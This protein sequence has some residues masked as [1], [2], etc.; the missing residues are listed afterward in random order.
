MRGYTKSKSWGITG[1]D[2]GT[3]FGLARDAWAHH[4]ALTGEAN[5]FE[6]A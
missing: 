5:P 1:D 4:Q 3:M 2:E 6:D